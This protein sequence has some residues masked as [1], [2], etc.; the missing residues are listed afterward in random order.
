MGWTVVKADADPIRATRATTKRL[1]NLLMVDVSSRF[2]V[3]I[4]T[5][6]VDNKKCHLIVECI[7]V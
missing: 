1:K 7:M 3:L 5:D 6:L 4:C 2:L